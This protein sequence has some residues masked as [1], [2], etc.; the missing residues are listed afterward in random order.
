MKKSLLYLTALVC[1]QVGATPASTI[2]KIA[3]INCNDIGSEDRVVKGEVFSEVSTETGE[4]GTTYVDLR[5]LRYEGNPAAPTAI[6]KWTRV[7]VQ[8][9]GPFSVAFSDSRVFFEA[10]YDDV[11]A[12]SELNYDGTSVQLQCDIQT[13]DPVATKFQKFQLQTNSP[14]PTIVQSPIEYASQHSKRFAEGDSNEISGWAPCFETENLGYSIR[15]ACRGTRSV[16]IRGGEMEKVPYRC[17]YAFAFALASMYAVSE[18][19]CE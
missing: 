18:A 11:G 9:S 15:I 16:L 13:Q 6:R 3:K 12:M 19:N 4:A 14:Q 5:Y 10:V 8:R 2:T 7:P 1:V 17:D